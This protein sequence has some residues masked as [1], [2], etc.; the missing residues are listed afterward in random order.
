MSQSVATSSPVPAAYRLI[1]A[2]INVSRLPS[3]LPLD[4]AELP[5]IRAVQQL[6]LA[7]AQG[8]LPEHAYR[9]KFDQAE[10]RRR[11]EVIVEGST[12][13]GLP[14]GLDGEILH[15]IFTL[16]DQY[17]SDGMLHD[18]SFRRIAEALG[19]SWNADVGDRIR[20][21]LF[22]LA[23]VRI[24]GHT[25]PDPEL[26]AAIER[27]EASPLPPT[28]R[29]TVLKSA[30]VQNIFNVAYVDVDGESWLDHIE[31]NSNFIGLGING[32]LAWID[33]PLYTH[34]G[35]PIA[36]RLYEIAA[37]HCAR[38]LPGPWTIPVDR[39]IASCG[40]PAP[41][42]PQEASKWRGNLVANGE[43]LVEASILRFFEVKK[44]RPKVYAATMMPGAALDP[45]IL[46]RGVGLLDGVETRILLLGLWAVG[47]TGSP[48]RRMVEDNPEAVFWAL[49]YLR[50]V[51]DVLPERDQITNPA[52]F[53]RRVVEDKRNLAADQNFREWYERKLESELPP[54]PNFPELE[55][56][57]QPLLPAPPAPLPTG[58][59]RAEQ[60]WSEVRNRIIE[61]HG[62]NTAPRIYLSDMVALRI[63]DG[64]LVL[65][66]RNS[67]A[68][69]W[70]HK[71]IAT[72]IEE[73]LSA[74]TSDAI[75]HFDILVVA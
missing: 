13:H 60:I 71:K 28:T 3:P 42:S 30:T 40:V 47:L 6:E 58:D 62:P 59:P 32:W 34:L 29:R 74:L 27:G 70:V 49:L 18:V 43:V 54:I 23:N 22:R 69:E 31:I 75:T 55:R 25:Q 15:A 17:G 14:Y 52:G 46:L 7:G 26:A 33:L 67:F 44:I 5:I 72:E 56:V 20:G 24:I 9:A 16:Y 1:L 48:S 36:Q 41:G 73:E 12:T 37:A 66:T 65:H 57:A 53:V 11:T 45:A 2:G 51:E 68:L 50:Y 10:G 39:I 61:R 64:C 35:R 4:L 21:A 38:G 63:D 8:M 19:K